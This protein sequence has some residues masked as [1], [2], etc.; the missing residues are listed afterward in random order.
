MG[1]I[2]IKKGLDLPLAGQPQQQ[3]HAGGQVKHVA[4]LGPDYVGMKP[5][6]AVQTGDHVQ[7][8]DVLFTDKKNQRVAYTAPG[9]GKI[10]AV[11]RGDKR[12]FLS[13]VIELSAQ[14][15]DKVFPS[16]QLSD[17]E[18]LSKE[19]ITTSL[20]ETGL[21]PSIKM[22]PFGKVANPDDVPNSLF[23][24]VMDTNPLA[25]DMAVVVNESIK[26][27]SAGLQVLSILVAKVYVC[28]ANRNFIPALKAD[29]IVVQEFSG[30]H[31][32]G[33][34]GTHIHLLDPVDRH[35]IV[36][37][38]GAQEV[39]AIGSFF[40]SGK[41]SHEKIVALAGPGV[42][43]PRLIR[44]RIGASVSELLSS[45]EIAAHQRIIS[46]SV[47][48]GHTA[49]DALDFIGRFDQ[50][51]TVIPEG[52]KRP[53]LGWMGPGLDL[54]STCNVVLGKFFRNNLKFTTALNG[55]KRSIVPIG[56]FEKVMPLDLEPTFL[57]KALAVDDV[58]EAELLGCLELIE[59]DLALC[60]YVCPAKIDHG[61]ELRRN[62]DI[63]EK[64]G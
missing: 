19:Q 8:G 32:A 21:W 2:K 1:L 59:E 51:I 34:S 9:A 44:A 46:G 55:G 38:I 15:E 49:A 64:E 12:A 17:L 36:W 39:I 47:L 7:C 4:L 14:E 24:N 16:F 61:L 43:N 13:V 45:E 41:I 31:P 62:L 18:L 35:K 25:P 30:P 6:M 22:R 40:L 26:E 52:D 57:L 5:T 48:N 60:T 29:N 53:F 63:I 42:K 56:T 50:Q 10:V 11:N 20:L 37:T 54:Y 58:E 28:T 33:N 27:F 23:V 3:V